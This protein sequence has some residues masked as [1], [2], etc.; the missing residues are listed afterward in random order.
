MVLTEIVDLVRTLFVRTK[1]TINT[2]LALT[3]G[4]LQS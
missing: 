1:S 4:L 2:V 3:L